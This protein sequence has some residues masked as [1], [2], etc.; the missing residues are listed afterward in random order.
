MCIDPVSICVVGEGCFSDAGQKILLT[1]ALAVFEFLSSA[2]RKQT[3]LT[4]SLDI[5]QQQLRPKR[6]HLG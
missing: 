5:I 6:H 1:A 2:W 3:P 4:R